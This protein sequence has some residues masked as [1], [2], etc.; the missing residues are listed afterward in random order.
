MGYIYILTSPSGK[1]YIGQTT[2][3]I[4]KR[5]E[6]HEIGKSTNCRG[7]YNAIRKYGWDNF[8]KDWYEC[9]DSDLNK[10]EE[11]MEEVLGTL[12]PEGYNLRKGGGNRGKPCEESKQRMSESQLGK[13]RS[14]ESKK[15]QGKSIEGEKNHNFGIPLSKESKQKLR[16]ANLGK[17][18]GKETKQKI[19]DSTKGE[20][21]HNS[22]KVYQYDLEE[23]LLGSFAS[24]GEAERHLRGK[25]GSN[26]RACMWG[27]SKTAYGFKWSYNTPY[28]SLPNISPSSPE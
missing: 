27:R 9:P 1:S 21:N 19:S 11:L 10:H 24:T 4:E 20:K 23:N 6:E 17:T 8:E 13:I 5:F 18:M 3:S 26:V 16:D 7:I 2:R 28:R 25:D 15:K 12:A 22:K 14:E